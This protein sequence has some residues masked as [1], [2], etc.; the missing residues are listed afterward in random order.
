MTSGIRLVKLASTLEIAL[1][2][3]RGSSVRPVTMARLAGPGGHPWSMVFGGGKP[4]RVVPVLGCGAREPDAS[5]ALHKES[6][7]V[8]EVIS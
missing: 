4:I 7:A 6:G 1:L 3:C 2:H 8:L 5:L